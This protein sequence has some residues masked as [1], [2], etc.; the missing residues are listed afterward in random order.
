MVKL[1]FGGWRF[2]PL[3]LFPTT[4]SRYPDA[5]IHGHCMPIRFLKFLRQTILVS[6][7]RSGRLSVWKRGKPDTLFADN[8]D[9]SFSMVNWSCVGTY[10]FDF[11]VCCVDISEGGHIVAAS[12]S[13]AVELVCVKKGCMQP[14][15]SFSIYAD[16]T[17]H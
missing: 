13:G 11:D 2:V 12:E 1:L 6:C 17:V 14:A 4:K 9:E 7:C 10:K 8:G 3:H 15:L 5:K 16:S